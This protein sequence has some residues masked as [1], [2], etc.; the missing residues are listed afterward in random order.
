VGVEIFKPYLEKSKKARIHTRYL[1]QKIEEADFPP[2]CFD[3]VVMI[4]VIEHLPKKVGLALIKKA[5][6]WAKKKVIISTPNGFLP[7]SRINNN[8][9]EKH[10]S[11]WDLKTINKLGYKSRGLAG[12]KFLRQKSQ[13]P[14]AIRNLTSSIKYRPKIFWFVIAT[15]S[16]LITYHF[17]QLAFELFNVKKL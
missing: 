6:Q 8:P 3:A 16:Q 17:P 1:H 2:K 13:G 5:E 11:G 4:E 15:L 7:Q 9:W 14:A 10:L 12:L